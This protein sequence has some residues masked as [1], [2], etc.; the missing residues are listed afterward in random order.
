MASAR[1]LA[2]TRRHPLE[3]DHMLMHCCPRTHSFRCPMDEGPGQRPPYHCRQQSLS[4]LQSDPNC[5]WESIE[6]VHH[7]SPSLVHRTCRCGQAEEPSCIQAE[8]LEQEIVRW[9]RMCQHLSAATQEQPM[10][11]VTQVA[12]RK[13][14]SPLCFNLSQ[15]SAVTGKY[16][17]KG[18]IYR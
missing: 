10:R 16:W 17:V 13:S 1:A 15:L 3:A 4:T 9:I 6:T 18:F 11:W 14:R 5:F 12:R 2:R 8:N 7:G